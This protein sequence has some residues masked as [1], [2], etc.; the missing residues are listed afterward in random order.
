VIWGALERTW[1]EGGGQE[2]RRQAEQQDAQFH[3]VQ[4]PLQTQQQPWRH[5]WHPCSLARQARDFSVV[6]L[7]R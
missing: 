3:Q 4:G 5:H 2:Q 1:F 6:P 7:L